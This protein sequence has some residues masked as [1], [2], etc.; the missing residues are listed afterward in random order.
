MGST[1]AGHGVMIRR[2]PRAAAFPTLFLASSFLALACGVSAQATVNVPLD[3]PAYAE[4]DVLRAAGL[5]A[6]SS[7]GQQP[8]SRL[9]FAR[10]TRAALAR[11]DAQPGQDRRDSVLRS[12]ERE[13]LSLLESRFSEEI[14]C[15]RGVEDPEASRVPVCDEPGLTLRPRLLRGDITRLSSPWRVVP[16]V[17]S[18]PS[19]NIDARLNPLVDEQLGRSV[20]DGWTTGIEAGFEARV[21]RYVT[22]YAHPRVSR[23]TPRGASSDTRVTWHQV[24]LRSVVGNL[25]VEIGRDHRFSGQGAAAGTIISLN[26]RGFDM[27]LASNDRPFYLPWVLE[28]L[29]PAS[30]LVMAA[31]LGSNRDIEDALLFLIRASIR[32]HPSF[33]IGF[34]NLNVQGGEGAPTGDFLDRVVD[35]LVPGIQLPQFSEKLVG[36][37]ARWTLPKPGVELYME[38]TNTDPDFRRFA[39]AVTNEAAW[40][41]GASMPSFGPEGRWSFRTEWR[42]NGFRPYTHHQYTS[43]LTLDSLVLGSPMGPAASGVAGQVGWSGT[44]H[45]FM[46]D[47]AWERYSGDTYSNISDPETGR[48]SWVKTADNPDEIR[49]RLEATW[50]RQSTEKRVRPSVRIGWESVDRFAFGDQGRTNW[51]AAVTLEYHW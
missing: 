21:G 17:Y 37:D 7:A 39:Q 51:V 10:L 5:V 14:E 30:M 40:L 18:L 34:S 27:I 44:T 33:E 45:R 31:D 50:T 13:A 29:G 4:L 25:A 9:E 26:P 22:A 43:G 42:R 38:F 12:R 15:L 35:V 32:P 20:V 16:T 28:A 6:E 11:A 23:L 41:V 8:Y 24:Y 47:G 48:L 49:Y 3:H 19:D 2:C 1:S 36:V 46:L